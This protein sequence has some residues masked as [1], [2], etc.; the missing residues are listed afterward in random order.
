[1]D[2]QTIDVAE[3]SLWLDVEGD[4]YIH[5]RDNAGGDALVHV[6]EIQALIKALQEVRDEIRG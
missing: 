5:I 2:E 4:D 1:M 3:D 6:S